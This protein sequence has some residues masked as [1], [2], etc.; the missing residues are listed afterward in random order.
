MWFGDLLPSWEDIKAKFG[1]W[2]EFNLGEWIGNKLGNLWQRITGVFSRMIN[3]LKSGVN[4]LIGKA[5][6]LIPGTKWDIPTFS[7]EKEGDF[8]E[9]TSTIT[10]FTT[11]GGSVTAED[12]AMEAERKAAVEAAFDAQGNTVIQNN[13]STGDQIIKTDIAS[14]DLSSEHSDSTAHAMAFKM[15]G[16]GGR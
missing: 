16:M 8:S 6:K 13:A 2:S 15:R 7:I 12:L 3:N 11:T 4:S 14:A 5:N 10:D 1:T 9:D